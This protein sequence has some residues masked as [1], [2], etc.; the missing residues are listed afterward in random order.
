[1]CCNP[2]DRHAWIVPIRLNERATDLVSS[3]DA[4][5]CQFDDTDV[6]VSDWDWVTLANSDDTEVLA[7]SFT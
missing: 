3:T 5:C 4:T 2:D 1:M 6:V 7:N